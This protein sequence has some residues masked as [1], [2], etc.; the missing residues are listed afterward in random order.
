MT[1]AYLRRGLAAGLAAGLLAGIFAY[2]FAEPIL[3]RAIELE[4]AAHEHTE[5]VFDRGEQK[6]G[7]ILATA[8]YGASVGA[9]FGL[10]SAFF[11]RRSLALSE[12]RRSLALAGAIF[13]GA[14]LLPFLK[15]PPNPPG[16]GADPAT[17]T[18]RT[19]AYLAMVALGLLAVLAAWRFAR[20]LEGVSLPMR[21]LT[22]GGILAGLWVFLYL[23]MPDFGGIGGHVPA[24]LVWDFRL[25]ALGTQVVLWAGIGC[26]FGLLG[27]RASRRKTL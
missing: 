15:Y 4:N 13:L 24:E 7:L 11:R 12:W 23:A 10:L 2:L 1:W 5:E 20:E 8:L 18:E 17:L 22:S 27:E 19:L 6:A 9:L 3:G 26:I 14:V 21:D 25:S 16:V